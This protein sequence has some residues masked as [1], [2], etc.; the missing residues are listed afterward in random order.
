M[1]PDLVPIWEGFWELRRCQAG[2]GYGP[3]PI[4]MEAFEAWW[5][6][7]PFHDWSDRRQVFALI[8]DLDTAY[9][10]HVMKVQDA[11]RKKR[12]REAKSKQNRAQ[13]H[14]GR[15]QRRG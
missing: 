9:M 3:N 2:T 4:S 10:A 6:S 8:K 7:N 1:Y 14:M 13:R 15:G 11:E 12:E 5:H